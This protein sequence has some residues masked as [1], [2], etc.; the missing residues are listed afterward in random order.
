MARLGQQ[1]GL[2]DARLPSMTTNR[3]QPFG[4]ASASA[5]ST[6]TWAFALQ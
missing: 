2:A 1:A 3:P 4:D 5:S 6:A